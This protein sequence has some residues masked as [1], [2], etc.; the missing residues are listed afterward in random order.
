[1]DQSQESRSVDRNTRVQL[2]VNYSALSIQDG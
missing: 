2:T 1:M